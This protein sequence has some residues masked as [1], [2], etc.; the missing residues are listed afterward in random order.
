MHVTLIQAILIAGVVALSNLDGNFFGEM[1][2]R[3]PLLLGSWL[4]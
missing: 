1:K 2:F 4:V 3:E